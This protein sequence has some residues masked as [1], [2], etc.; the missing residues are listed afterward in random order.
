MRL[1][2]TSVEMRNNSNIICFVYI[3][4]NLRDKSQLNAKNWTQ[5]I[6]S[7]HTLTRYSFG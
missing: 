1:V 7:T 6:K 5:S 2:K 4:I 3:N